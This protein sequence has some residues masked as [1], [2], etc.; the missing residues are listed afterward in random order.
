MV[1]GAINKVHES[2]K[3][4]HPV[5]TKGRLPQVKSSTQNSSKKSINP[6]FYRVCKKSSH[7]YCNCKV[8]KRTSEEQ[9]R[10]ENVNDFE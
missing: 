8:H 2:I 10:D 9:S 4:P 1:N 7:G 3:E 5:S 6:Q